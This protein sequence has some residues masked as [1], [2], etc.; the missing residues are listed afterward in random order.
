MVNKAELL[1]KLLPGFLPL[2]VFIAADWIYGT[3]TGILIAVGFGILEM[4]YTYIKNK[5]FDKFILYD[6][7]LLSLLGGVSYLLDN[8]IFFKL[9]PALI[10][11]IFCVI[12]GISVFSGKNIIMMMSKRY[13]RGVE[14]PP[15]YEQK[16]TGSLKN[17]FFI[18]IGHV[19]LIVYSAYF[20]SKEAWVF[21]SGGLFYIVFGVY[22]LWEYAR[23]K[24]WLKRDTEWLPIVDEQGQIKGKAPRD[25]CHGNPDLLHPVVHLHIMNKNN[26]LFLQKRPED[27]I[28]QPGKW[29]TAVGGHI[30]FGEALEQS[31]QREA[32][33]ELGIS[34]IKPKLIKKYVWKTDIESEL[35]F[36]FIAHYNSEIKINE[37]E[38][39]DGKFWSVEEIK[40]NIKE[41]IF[42][43]NF[44]KE[45]LILQN[46]IK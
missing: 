6:T 41:D 14:M 42:T 43:P 17:L 45:F 29:D 9:K 31:L 38:L 18:L 32:Q 8:D 27:K 40:D 19:L 21:I 13:M 3:Q 1:K 15:G 23:N 39:A 44:K 25:L 34:Q 20:M 22:F 4:G 10:E 35:V 12:L 16:M 26:Q 2:F 24:F 11:L 7:I 5:K 46:F 37:K 36:M 33:E 30:E 28:V